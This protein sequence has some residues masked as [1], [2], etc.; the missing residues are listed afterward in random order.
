MYNPLA[1]ITHLQYTSAF[2]AW[3][4]KSYRRKEDNKLIDGT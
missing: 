4:S 3:V 1:L 2:A